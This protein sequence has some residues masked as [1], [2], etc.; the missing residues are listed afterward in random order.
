MQTNPQAFDSRRYQ[1]IP[2]VLVFLNRGEDILLMKRAA[3]RRVFPGQ[4]NGLGG[5]VESG[6]NVLAAARREVVEESGLHAMDLWLCAIATIDTGDP[7][8]G[9]VMWVFRGTAEGEPSSTPEGENAWI[10]R[11]Q[12][13]GLPMVEDIPVLLPKILDMEPG[14]APLWA[15]Y[16][17][18]LEGQLQ[19]DF[20]TP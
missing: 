10:R 5:H 4:Y 8:T 9:I 11:D 15:H 1:V 13:T 7:R 2:R 3:D 12:L 20:E 18:T 19:M 17:Y 16:S 14:D 6:E